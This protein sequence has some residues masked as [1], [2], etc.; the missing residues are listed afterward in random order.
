MSVHFNHSVCTNQTLITELSGSNSTINKV[1]ANAAYMNLIITI[2]MSV[3]SLVVNLVI[4]PLSD[5]YGR[6]PVMMLVLVGELLGVVVVVIVTY[7][8]LNIYWFI[9]SALLIGFGGGVSTLQSVSFAY[10][11]DITP[12]RWRTLHIGFLQAMVYTGSR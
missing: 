6:K 10:V 12:T 5:K 1:E 2:S 3:P 4:S 9:L 8:N 11:S 7:L